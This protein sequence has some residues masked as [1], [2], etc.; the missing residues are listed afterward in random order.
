NG[1]F[2]FLRK[3]GG[4]LGVFLVLGL[5]DWLGFEPGRE[6]Q[7]ETARPAIRWMTAVAPACFLAVGVWL[8]RGH[9]LPP[10]RP[11]RVPPAPARRDA[12]PAQIQPSLRRAP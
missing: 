9:P 3:L 1:V 2:T 10:E 6:T 8:S 11:A 12:A 7:S 4:A 5:L